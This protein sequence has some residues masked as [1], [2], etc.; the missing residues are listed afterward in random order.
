MIRVL[1]WC[2]N[3]QNKT[4]ADVIA[5]YPEGMHNVIA[6]FLSAD[7]NITAAAATLDDPDCG[8]TDARLAE[9]DVILWWGHVGHDKVPDAVVEKLYKSVVS[10]GK[11]IICLHSAHFSKIFKRLMGTSCALSIPGSGFGAEKLWTLLPGHPIADGVPNPVD[12]EAEEMY[13]EFFDI[14]Q[15][16]ELVFNA[17]FEGCGSFRAGAAYHR[18][19]GKVFYFQP[20]HETYQVYR[21]KEIQDIILNAVYWANGKS[22]RA[23]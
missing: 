10:D 2:E 15:P 14:P 17:A 6:G 7:P 3:I 1:V 4:Q 19:R 8:I 13:N 11:G 23:P 22:R 9:T 18:G 12:I 21:K 20:G 16:D 5:A